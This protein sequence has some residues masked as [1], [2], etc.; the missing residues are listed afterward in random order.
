MNRSIYCL[1][2]EI[3]GESFFY[4]KESQAPEAMKVQMNIVVTY[5]T[6]TWNTLHLS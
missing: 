4:N 1:A 3:M 2:C 5:I 6:L